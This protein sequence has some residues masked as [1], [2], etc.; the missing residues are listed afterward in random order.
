MANCPYCGSTNIFRFRRD[1]DWGGRI[2]YYRITENGDCEDVDEMY[3]I[4]DIAVN[5]CEDCRGVFDPFRQI[6]MPPHIP[7][8]AMQERIDNL[9]EHLDF[10]TKEHN[11]IM[12]PLAKK[13]L[14]EGAEAFTKRASDIA[15]A[16]KQKAYLD[17]TAEVIAT[18]EYILEKDA[19]PAAEK[20]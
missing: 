2:D 13:I 12:V 8:S 5:F 10:K 18:L 14:R 9:R 3:P 20:N 11:A 6:P 7:V 4:P 16:Q 17:Q 19:V 15:D 1:L